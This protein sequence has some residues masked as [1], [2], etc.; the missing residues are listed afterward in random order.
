MFP[1]VIKK[2]KKKGDKFQLKFMNLV[3]LN[4]EPFLGHI[5]FKLLNFLCGMREKK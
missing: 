3:G 2:K 4:L 1:R 5:L